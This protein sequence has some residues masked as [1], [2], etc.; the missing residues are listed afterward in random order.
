MKILM[1]T[2]YVPYPPSSGGQIRT[3]NLLKHLY[4]NN[5]ITL[6]CLYKD[7]EEKKYFENLKTY[8]RA[9]YFCR[10]AKV[11]W[12][13]YIVFRSIFS[14]KP[15]LIVRNYSQEAEVILRTLLTKEKFDIIHAETF[16]IMP[17]LPK[18]KVPIFLVEQT[19]EY[20]VYQH[21]IQGLPAIIRLLFY[22]D[23]IKLKFWERKY[24]TVAAKVGAVSGADK[25]EIT[26]LEPMIKP[27]V[28]PNGAGDEMIVQTLLKKTLKNPQ[29]VFVGNFSWLQNVE[30]AHYLI[31]NIYP[32]LAISIPGISVKI[33]GQVATK[34][35]KMQAN[36]GI[37][38]VDIKPTDGATIKK[39]Y[40]EATLFIAPI[41]GPGGT[42]LK[43]LAAM[44]AGL[45]VVSTKTG[46]QGLALKNENSVLIANSSSDF[47]RQVKR[48]L[49][50]QNLYDKI[51][52]NAYEL[53]KNIY[54]WGNISNKLE[55]VYQ[56]IVKPN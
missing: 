1:L 48:I 54:S 18:T 39:A 47:I 23:I 6:V 14:G 16:Y 24:W 32:K 51:Q 38:I 41:F 19:I 11:P 2:P 27:V 22:L 7:S 4:K 40:Q 45:P 3:F 36:L 34:K 53:V 30:A 42:R 56:T 21:F 50:D 15:F 10:R 44:A 8:C 52:K 43:I 28:V 46:V 55:A 17:H 13:P 33:I 20:K 29:I 31:N 37:E 5:E 26:K 12:Q 9:I 49:S 25:R 35:I